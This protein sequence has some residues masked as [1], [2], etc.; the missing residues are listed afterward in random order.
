[1][2]RENHAPSA[3][4]ASLAQGANGGLRAPL[5]LRPS[6]APLSVGLQFSPGE[7]SAPTWPETTTQTAG[8]S[9]RPQ[10]TTGSLPS[11]QTSRQASA[12]G[13]S[14]FADA[15]DLD[16]VLMAVLTPG[17]SQCA[18]PGPS[19]HVSPR[20]ARSGPKRTEPAPEDTSSAPPAVILPPPNSEIRAGAQLEIGKSGPLRGQKSET[21]VTRP[22]H[23]TV[24]A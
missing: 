16:S 10:S 4:P 6:S 22:L 19:R 9:A 24:A 3:T 13:P 20:G 17:P 8:A 14:P 1:M 18:I 12:R 7:T 11:H 21:R 2:L 15:D 5:T 23:A